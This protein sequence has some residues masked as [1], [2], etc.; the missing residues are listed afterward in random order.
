MYKD[1]KLYKK[2][3]LNYYLL[4]RKWNIKKNL[5]QCNKFFHFNIT[6]FP[7]YNQ[8]SYI[9]KK[10]KLFLFLFIPILFY[11]SRIKFSSSHCKI[12]IYIQIL[13]FKN[14]FK[15]YH[16]YTYA[17]DNNKTITNI[18]LSCNVIIYFPQLIGLVFRVKNISMIIILF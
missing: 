6:I 12:A 4:I 5:L 14:S 17:Y 9:L 8:F 16:N 1:R 2:N 3:K 11:S 7:F 15:S 18:L 13:L 10:Y